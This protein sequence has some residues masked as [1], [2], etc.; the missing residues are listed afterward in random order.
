[1]P[2]GL[3]DYDTL[4]NIARAIRYKANTNRD[5]RPRDMA[6]AIN[7]IKS[8][9][10]FDEPF[11]PSLSNYFM[12]IQNSL[13]DIT[14]IELVNHFPDYNNLPYGYREF[15]REYWPGISP[16]NIVV[17][18]YQAQQQRLLLKNAN[19]IGIISNGQNISNGVNTRSVEVNGN[20]VT[21]Q[22]GDVVMN[23]SQRYLV[24]SNANNNIC[25]QNVIRGSNTYAVS[26]SDIFGLPISINNDLY[27]N[28]SGNVLAIGYDGNFNENEFS[29]LDLTNA[30][31]YALMNNFVGP[32][33]CGKYTRY[34]AYAYNSCYGA[35]ITSPACGP[36]VVNMANAYYSCSNMI[37]NGKCGNNVRNMA[38]AYY[39]CI[40]LESGELGENVI[41]AY[42]AYYGCSNIR[43]MYGNLSHVVDGAYAF[44]YCT[45]LR[46]MSHFNFPILYN[47]QSMFSGC[48]NLQSIPNE[49][50]DLMHA[51]GMFYGCNNLTMMP[52]CPKLIDA[53]GM[54]QEVRSLT[55][56]DIQ[57]FI[58]YHVNLNDLSSMFEFGSTADKAN[59]LNLNFPE[60][61]I[62]INRLFS[63]NPNYNTGIYDEPNKAYIYAPWV[64]GTA[65]CPDMVKY[66]S[67]TYAWDNFLTDAACGNNVIMMDHSFYYC[68]NLINAA[69]GS[70]VT[71]MQNTYE[72]CINLMNAACGENVE[73]M[74]VTYANCISLE[75]AVCGPNVKLMYLTYNNCRGLINGACS[76]SVENMYATYKN[77]VNLIRTECGNNVLY[78]S[79]TYNGC[80]NLI[81]GVCGPN[82]VTMYRA[83]Y[84]CFNLRSINIG[85]NVNGLYGT[86]ERCY[87]LTDI[88]LGKN[89]TNISYAFNFANNITNIY[90]AGN[91]YQ[92]SNAFNNK[93]KVANIE[94]DPDLAGNL[95]YCFQNCKGIQNVPAIPNGVNNIRLMFWNCINIVTDITI[96]TGVQDIGNAFFNAYKINNF[97]LD[98]WEIVNSG[99]TSVKILNAFYRG[100]GTYGNMRNIVVAN[101]EGWNNFIYYNGAGPMLY[102]NENYETPVEVNVNGNTYNCV[103]CA[104]NTTYNCYIYC[105]E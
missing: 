49:F 79:E 58:D 59:L 17:Y 105:M 92:I 98:G 89:I 13:Y 38:N 70:N 10:G 65:L 2:Y 52:K 71:T 33:I 80:S 25:W 39:G 83:Y 26:T 24:L 103:R 66:I 3:I 6:Q 42:Y 43:A 57:N 69:C 88:R 63:G 36:N 93:Q 97:Y 87:N 94:F 11:I 21:A 100:Y 34:M 68:Y 9:G 51:S 96:G 30:F 41:N 77:C 1:M 67:Y 85:N 101:H 8:G 46:D 62:S 37:G 56:E 20:P 47:G 29:I 76:D 91:Y 84:N 35:Q 44:S 5:Y 18:S 53:T 45:N 81:E 95:S 72:N 82:V 15:G 23:T 54:F 75:N 104:Y 16:A 90:L 32:A 73:T 4:K 86:F 27:Y 22:I 64:T 7:T 12:N 14:R 19:F 60:R 102:T 55:T 61:I 74:N 50:P 40:G 78:L 99:A 31:S 28:V 48:T